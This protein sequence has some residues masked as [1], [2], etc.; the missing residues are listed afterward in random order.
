[1]SGNLQR[2]ELSEGLA[3]PIGGADEIARLDQAIHSLATALSAK[4]LE[5][6]VFLYSVSHDLRSPLVNLSGF[7]DEL[8][9][10]T[11]ELR[12]MLEECQKE[13][14][15]SG[16]MLTPAISMIDKDFERSFVFLR[17]AVSRL[18]RIIDALLKLSRVG[19]V[20]Y[21]NDP[22]DLEAV[23]QRVVVALANSVEQSKAEIKLSK[24]PTVFGDETAY[25]QIF[26]NLISN[27]ITYRD[28]ARPLVIEVM[29][30]PNPAL[31]QLETIMVSDNGLGMSAG[32]AKKLFLA[33][34]RFRPEIGSGEGIGLAIVRRV[35]S[36]LGGKIWCETEDGVGSRFYVALPRSAEQ[37]VAVPDAII[38]L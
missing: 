4:A 12:T 22:I 25:E 20:Q 5:T 34:Q 35:V 32:A 8:K 19:R 27:A 31:P 9:L 10:S 38:G 14:P 36:S 37:K 16:R 13:L 3:P 33:F 28:P 17:T 1:M 18:S 7:T 15:E 6:E 26:G 21:R 24:L 11:G 30:V 23:V 29:V 2:L